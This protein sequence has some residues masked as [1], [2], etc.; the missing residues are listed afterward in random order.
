MEMKDDQFK[1]NCELV[2]Q[3]ITDYHS[4]LND[5]STPVIGNVKPGQIYEAFDK[6]INEDGE[7]DLNLLLTEVME[8]IVPG[9]CNWSHPDN[10]AWLPNIHSKIS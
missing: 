7:Q 3:F 2:A 5:G 6:Q 1:K 4:K 8:K 9:M 10:I